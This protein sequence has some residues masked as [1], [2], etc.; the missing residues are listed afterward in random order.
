MSEIRK[1]NEPWIF[2]FRQNQE[3]DIVDTILKNVYME[4]ME[5]DLV[6]S[7]K[8]IRTDSYT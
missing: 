2:Y 1:M 7:Q 3:I 4:E 8:T 6:S 5:E